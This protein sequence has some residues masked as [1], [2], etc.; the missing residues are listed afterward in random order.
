MKKTRI[1]KITRPN[2]TIYYRIQ[3]RFF[4][5][6]GWWYNESDIYNSYEEAKKSLYLFDGTGDKEEVLFEK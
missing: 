4:W 3:T 5:F 2:K 6:F 1:V